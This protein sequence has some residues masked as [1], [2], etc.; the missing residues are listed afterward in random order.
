MIINGMVYGPDACQCLPHG[1]IYWHE[2]HCCLRE[3]PDD[4][5][6]A[7]TALPCGHVY[8]IGDDAPELPIR[9]DQ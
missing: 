2:G 3:M 5:P 9:G 7:G 6:G 8:L 1:S 4:H